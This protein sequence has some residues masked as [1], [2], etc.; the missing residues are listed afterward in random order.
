MPYCNGEWKFCK[1][2]RLALRGFISPMQ[3]D[4]RPFHVARYTS[5]VAIGLFDC[6]ELAIGH[7]VGPL[8]PGCG[9]YT[10]SRYGTVTADE[11]I[12][13]TVTFYL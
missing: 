6:V 11:E 4:I 13:G 5:S 1:A 3:G 2:S 10:Y 8:A 12:G 7:L 9:Q